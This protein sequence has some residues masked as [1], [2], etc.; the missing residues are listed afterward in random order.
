MRENSKQDLNTNVLEING[1]SALLVASSVAIQSVACHSVLK[2]AIMSNIY[3]QT[4]NSKWENQGYDQI[5]SF[6]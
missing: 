6:L 4:V 5:L 1:A 2:D 3:A